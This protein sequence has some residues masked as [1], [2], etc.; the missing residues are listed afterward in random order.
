LIAQAEREE[1]DTRIRKHEVIEW[2]IVDKFVQHMVGNCFFGELERLQHEFPASLKGRS[3]LEVFEEVKRQIDQVK[4][5]LQQ[6]LAS[7]VIEN[8]PKPAGKK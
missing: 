5:S 2:S 3:E 8:E 4:K 6:N 1:I 7:F